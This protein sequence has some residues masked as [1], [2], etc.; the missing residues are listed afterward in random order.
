MTTPSGGLLSSS[1]LARR[2]DIVSSLVD[3]SLHAG[4][5]LLTLRRDFDRHTHRSETEK[6]LVFRS[7]L[8]LREGIA[9]TRDISSCSHLEDEINEKILEQNSQFVV[10]LFV[11]TGSVLL[12]SN[13]LQKNGTELLASAIL[14]NGVLACIDALVGGFYLDSISSKRV[15]YT[16]R[17]RRKMVVEEIKRAVETTDEERKEGKEGNFSSF[18]PAWYY[19]APLLV[20][21]LLL[22]PIRYIRH[23]PNLRGMKKV[24][25]AF[26]GGVASCSLIGV[27]IAVLHSTVGLAQERRTLRH[28]V[29]LLIDSLLKEGEGQKKD[30]KKAIFLRIGK[31][32][33]AAPLTDEEEERNKR[34]E[35]INRDVTHKTIVFSLLLLSIVVFVLA[36]KRQLLPKAC[37][38]AGITLLVE[39]SFLLLVKARYT[40]LG[41]ASFERNVSTRRSKR[42]KDPKQH[43]RESSH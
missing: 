10:A 2:E 30:A 23:D 25:E 26:L 7:V 5:I 28:N 43:H 31:E 29:S 9:T 4:V 3:A 12:T 20:S 14:E 37:V 36:K 41:Y 17:E 21:F 35:T 27:A 15:V 33:E 32:M 34:E 18:L 38:A 8:P 22:V 6:E 24:E 19:A 1:K 40:P 39:V 16:E 42:Q 11:V 13:V